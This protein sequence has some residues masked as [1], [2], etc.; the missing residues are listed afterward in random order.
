MVYIKVK[1]SRPSVMLVKFQT[2]FTVS[3]KKTYFTFVP[4]VPSTKKDKFPV[5][6]AEDNILY[7]LN[8]KVVFFPIFR[9]LKMFISVETVSFVEFDIVDSIVYRFSVYGI[10]HHPRAVSILYIVQI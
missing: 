4:E 10:V 7:L 6:C 8:C 9:C 5:N 3:L 1:A 2:Y